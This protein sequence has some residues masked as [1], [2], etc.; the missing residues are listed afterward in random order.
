[1]NGIS[2]LSLCP[3]LNNL[4]LTN[5]AIVITSDYRQKIKSNLPLLLILDG[6]GFD[7]TNMNAN[8]TECSSSLSSEFSKDS[9][10]SISDRSSESASRPI[11]TNNQLNVSVANDVY[12][13]SSTIGKF[14][15]I[16][17]KIC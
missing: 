5:N 3:K 17:T 4:D 12:R 16:W 15:Y 2:F 1:M 11:S 7:E 8:L 6:F 9:N 10:Y 13:R 14:K